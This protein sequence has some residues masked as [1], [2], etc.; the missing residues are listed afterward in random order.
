VQAVAGHPDP[1]RLD[2]KL[3]DVYFKLGDLTKERHYRELVWG[4]LNPPLSAAE[5]AR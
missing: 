4:A 2:Q 5:R 1:A 3:S